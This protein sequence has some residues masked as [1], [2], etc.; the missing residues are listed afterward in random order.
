MV[1]VSAFYFNCKWSSPFEERL[2]KPGL[3]H[4]SRGVSR[5]VKMMHK[6]VLTKYYS[7]DSRGRVVQSH[8]DVMIE[9]HTLQCKCY[10]CPTT[11]RDESSARSGTVPS[12]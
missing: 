2:T 7:E 3:F 4:V 1:I 5:D 12:A 6:Q 11:V 9:D 8:S 10:P